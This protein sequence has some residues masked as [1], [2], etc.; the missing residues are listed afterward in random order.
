MYKNT[1]LPEKCPPIEAKQ[2]ENSL[3][4]YRII[5]TEKLCEDAFLTYRQLYP[6]NKRY[7]NL[8][9]AFAVSMFTKAEFAMSAYRASIERNKILGTHL[10]ELIL[11]PNDGVFEIN[12]SSGHCSFWFYES[13]N[14]AEIPCVQIIQIDE[15]T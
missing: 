10:A 8:C 11:K 15:N 4:L 12:P 7:R 3:T 1:P 14:F 13:C 9:V 5:T 6:E 2:P